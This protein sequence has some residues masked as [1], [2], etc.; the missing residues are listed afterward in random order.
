MKK[1]GTGFVVESSQ[2]G[3]LHILFYGE[4][5]V[6]FAYSEELQPPPS[7]VAVVGKPV[8]LGGVPE[9]ESLISGLFKIDV[10]R[11]TL[12]VKISDR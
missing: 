12:K 9:E 5:I 11:E 10:D 4:N 7:S 6:R 2:G 3:Y 1:N 8:D